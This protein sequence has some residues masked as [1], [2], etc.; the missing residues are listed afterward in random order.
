MQPLSI[1]SSAAKTA[2]QSRVP[3]AWYRLTRMEYWP[4]WILFFPQ[5]I[6]LFW[7]S[8]TRLKLTFLTALNPGIYLSGLYGESKK[9]ILDLIPEKLLPGQIF[10]PALSDLSDLEKRIVDANI[11]FPVILKPNAGERGNGVQKI[12]EYDQL[13]A[14]INQQKQDYILQEFIDYP[15][16]AGVFFYAY[17]DGSEFKITSITLKIFLSV[18]GKGAFT[19]QELLEQTVR[20]RMQIERLAKIQPALLK[21]IP[22]Q[23]QKMVIDPIGN[24]CRGTE[25]RD[26]RKFITPKMEQNLRQIVN[27]IQGVYYGRFDIKYRSLEALENGDF[28]VMELNGLTSEP[29]HIYDPQ[30]NIFKA[31]KDITFHT[32]KMMQI[33]GQNVKRGVKP[34][35]IKEVWTCVKHHFF[36]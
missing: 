25:F 15:H 33:C 3:L 35:P 8:I 23:G 10:I 17:P 30:Y 21:T 16:E 20:G 1:S 5:Y 29:T 27:Q 2:K 32:Y 31:W 18:E 11:A 12:Y 6:L 36:N 9:D 13:L 28:K 7:Y 24:H 34:A 19:V 22:L 26:G 14:I 4:V